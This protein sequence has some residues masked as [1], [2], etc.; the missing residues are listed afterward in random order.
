MRLIIETDRVGSTFLV[1]KIGRILCL[2]YF[3]ATRTHRLVSG[4]GWTWELKGKDLTE[5]GKGDGEEG[6]GARSQTWDVDFK[7]HNRHKF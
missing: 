4:A 7:L 6:R 3:K 1:R 5:K 2:F